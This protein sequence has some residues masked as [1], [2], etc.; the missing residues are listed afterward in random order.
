MHNTNRLSKPLKGGCFGTGKYEL[1]TE[2][3]ICDGMHAV[4]YIVSQVDT[5]GAIAIGTSK[6]QAMGSARRLLIA[7]QD[8]GRSPGQQLCLWSDADL[9][10]AASTRPED[11]PCAPARRLAA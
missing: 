7:T 8:A 10:A 11:P 9:Q 3:I 5:G 2:P 4:R 1:L 6:G